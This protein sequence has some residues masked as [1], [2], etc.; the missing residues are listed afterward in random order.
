VRILLVEDEPNAARLLA[1]GLVEQAYAVDTADDGNRALEL[2]S[3][4]DYDLVILD[5]MLPG[6]DGLAVCRELRATGFV[7]PIL[8]LTARDTI[9]HR[10]SGLD[11]GAD[12]YLVKPFDF[13]ELLARIRALLRRAPALQREVIRVADL[14]V[15]TRA[16]RVTR[17]GQPI[18][19]TA[20]E[21]S[22]IEY[23]ARREGDI[24]RRD[25]IAEHVWDHNFDPLSNLIEV[26]I[27]RLR[28]KIDET[29]AVKLL[30]TKRGLGYTLK[31]DKDSR[32]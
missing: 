32:D 10:V 11:C 18:N 25:E 7:M 17:S 21:Y 5:V 23:L 6:K 16:R 20:K 30:H 26:Y 15:D 13:R 4:A 12:D 28:R 9:E 22:L 14:T 19:L 8:M 2:A 27:R 31:P 1:K 29:Y 3:A 24:V